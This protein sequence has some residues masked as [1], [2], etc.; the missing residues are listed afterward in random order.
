MSSTEIKGTL[1]ACG[2]FAA[3]GSLVAASDVIEGYPFAAGQAVRYAAAAGLLVIIARGR[4]PI[5]TVREALY[6]VALAATG[7]VLFNVFVIA[8]VREADPATVGVIIGCVPIVLALLGPAIERRPV[9]L[10]VAA[11]AVIVAA[12]AA[13]V[14]YSGGDLTAIALAFALGALACEAAFSLFAVPV[15]ERLGALAVSAYACIAAA[16]LLAIWALADAGATLPTP[17]T[18]QALAFAYLAF[19]VTTGGFLLW[20]TSI[21]LLGVERAGLFSGVL[22]ISALACS[23]A[24]GAAEI[25]PVR[26]LGVAVVAAGVTLGMRAKS[27]GDTLKGARER[28]L[29][30]IAEPAGQLGHGGALVL[31]PAVPHLH[32]PA[33]HVPH[34]ELA[35]EV[36]EARAANA[37]RDI[38]SGRRVHG[39]ASI[40]ANRPRIGREARSDVRS[41][42]RPISSPPTA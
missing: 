12:G 29:R 30:A 11:A 4:L 10:S 20:Y 6:L 31:E 42:L 18:A 32:A 35:D 22:P 13:G 24:I 25:T 19:G 8:G 16:P 38:T 36:G 37:D 2:A 26:L 27:S 33:R 41:S 34:D 1:A 39:A 14:E 23:A 21:R 7:L 17:T 15:L 28:T 40:S 3:V 9:R 5:P